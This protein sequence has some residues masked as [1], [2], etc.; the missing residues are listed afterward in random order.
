MIQVPTR[1]EV[2]AVAL[3]HPDARIEILVT[4]GRQLS[5]ELQD[6]KSFRYGL[7]N[8]GARDC[9]EAMDVVADCT[10]RLPFTFLEDLPRDES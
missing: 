1:E 6:G 4:S 8:V 5:H 9:R 2:A 3:C 7:I 10:R